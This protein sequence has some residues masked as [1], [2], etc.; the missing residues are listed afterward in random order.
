MTDEN[1]ISIVEKVLIDFNNDIVNS[2][3]KKGTKAVPVNT[4]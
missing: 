4:K 3:A 2:L 1:V